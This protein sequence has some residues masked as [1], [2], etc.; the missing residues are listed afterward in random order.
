MEREMNIDRLDNDEE[1]RR[2]EFP[3]CAEKI[4]LAHAAVSPLPGRVTE[5]MRD[6]LE[7]AARDDQE[8]VVT[9]AVVR[10]TRQLAARL[11]GARA[12]EIAFA[13][14]TSMGLAM[15]AGG[16]DWRRGDNVVCYRADYPA[17]VY[18]WMDLARRG[19]QARFVQ[20]RRYGN[21]TVEDVGRA[22]DA[23]TR[24]VALASAHF[25]SGW[26]LDTDGIGRFLRERGV[27]FCLDGI[28][29]FGAL[30]TVVDHVDFAAADAHKWML[31][32]VGI[33]I[34]F[35]RRENFQRLHPALVG[36]NSAPCPDFI[37]QEQVRLWP[38]ARRYEPGSLNL[39]GIVGLRAALRM[40]LAVTDDGGRQAVGAIEHRVL[41]LAGRLIAGAVE[42]GWE[43]VGP[44]EGAGLSA[45]VSLS[46]PG[47][48]PRQLHTSLAGANIIASLRRRHDGPACLRFSPHFYNTAGEIGQVLEYL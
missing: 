30:R 28:Q 42:R 48:D 1:L 31:G 38:D 8:R 24:L 43:I 33:A 37:A 40:I 11:I 14:S 22:L 23:R 4:F 46:A 5:A 21:V 15:V 44:H 18:P 39:A 29:S 12:E 36:C 19:V 26:R 7:R 2:R 16:V 25:V 41:Q 10:E 27:L 34:L 3:V 13:G 17:N 32:P 20:P 47:K 35:V 9:D 6:Y 45:I